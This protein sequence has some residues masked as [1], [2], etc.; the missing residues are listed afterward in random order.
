MLA[1]GRARPDLGPLF[2]EPTILTGVTPDMTLYDHE[3]FG[4]VVSIYSFG[5]VDEAIER[6]NATAYGL[7]ASVWTR[8]GAKGRAVAARVHAGTVNVND[9]YAAAWGSVDSP[10]GGMGDSG[11]G[12]RHGADGMLKYTEA[13][14][15]AHQRVLGFS[16]PSGF[17]GSAWAST[18]TV[19][20]KGMKRLGAHRRSERVTVVSNG[21][22]GVVMTGGLRDGQTL[23]VHGGGSGIGTHAIQ[24]G[25]ALSAPVAVTAGS[26]YK[27]DRC[28]ELGANTLIN[29]R[30]DDF[31]KIVTAEYGGADVILDI[32]GAGYLQR[33]VQALAENGDLT[34]IGLQDGAAAELD[35]GLILFKRASVHVTNLRRRARSGP[36]SKA[37]IIAELRQ[38]LWPLI[39]EGAVA[40][41]VSA[42]IPVTDVAAAHPLLDSGETVGKVLLTIREP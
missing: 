34:I 1:G 4:P 32:M 8:D 20:L 17:S 40:P 39:A 26:Q 2:Y 41:V 15:V 29:Y 22:R 3:T 23:L 10:M 33:N 13:Q 28:A 6:A 21:C 12:R 5:D 24:V 16:A 38:K 36:G 31:V 37:E 25:R 18:L 42:E 11:L 19:V 30:Y 7:N 9:A 35:L 14:T 27:L